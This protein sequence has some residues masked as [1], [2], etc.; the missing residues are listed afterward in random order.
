VLKGTLALHVKDA[1]ILLEEGETDTVKPQAAHWAT[2]DDEAVDN[3]T[4]LWDM[5]V[6]PVND[7]GDHSFVIRDTK[8]CTPTW[9]ATA[10]PPKMRT[11]TSHSGHK[12][13]STF[14]IGCYSSGR[15]PL[16]D[17]LPPTFLLDF[18]E[19]RVEELRTAAD[20]DAQLAESDHTTAFSSGDFPDAHD[21]DDI[22]T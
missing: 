14:R 1:S 3:Q 5:P 18:D 20:L 19:G 12:R 16:A 8:T 9:N 21:R 15:G 7:C 2:S 11:R 13:T 10:S 17:E 6:E 4:S 22:D